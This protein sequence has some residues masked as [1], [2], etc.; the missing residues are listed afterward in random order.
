MRRINLLYLSIPVMLYILLVI[1]Y[2]LN[3]STASFFGVAENQETQ[4]NLEHACAVNKIH[5]TQGQFV[6]KGT[7]LLEV[8]RSALEFK[9]SELSYDISELLARDRLNIDR[10]EGD[11][12]RLR[13]QRAEKLGTIQARIRLIE[14]EQ[15]LNRALFL[16]LQ[17]LPTS[18]SSITFTTPYMAKLQTLH[19]ELRL[20]LDPLD[21]EIQRLEQE[22]KIAAVP[23][24]TQVL[25][26]KEEI[27]LYQKQRE[28]LLIY[29]PSDGLIGSIHCHEGENISSFS[30]LI[31]F[32]EQHPNTIVA[33]LHESLSLQLKVGDSLSVASS[34]HP[35]QTCMGRVSG[36]GHRIVEIPERLRK[37]PEIKTYGREVLIDIT[38]GNKFLQKERV[39]V[40]QL[41]PPGTSLFSIF[42]KPLS[43]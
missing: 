1:Y 35:E 28:Q 23:A 9:M 40:Q 31:S 3:R 19:E 2:S 37:I 4:I 27:D 11:L 39:V 29:A 24:Q 36:L 22:L 18:D 26:L 41:N 25:K 13:A 14:S 38:N 33:Y 42:L 7:L 15:A 32:Y 34:L 6:S 30:T 43:N 5:V 12:A 8:S 21:V 10:I 17:N 20:A 16:D